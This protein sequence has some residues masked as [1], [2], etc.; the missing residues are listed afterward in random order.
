MFYGIP[1]GG[2]DEDCDALVK[3]VCKEVLKLTDI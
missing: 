1:E 2:K 3:D